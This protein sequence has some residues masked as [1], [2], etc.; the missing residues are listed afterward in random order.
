MKRKFVPSF[1]LAALLA[2]TGAVSLFGQ[3]AAP[4][5]EASVRIRKHVEYLTSD[6]L[7][8][9]RTGDPGAAAA[10]KYVADEFKKLKLQ[11]G[12]AV[13]GKKAGFMQPFPYV[14]GMTLANDSF[15]RIVPAD[16]QLES[17]TV[18]GETYM[19][20]ANSANG[21]VPDSTIVFA[22]YGIT[23]QDKSYDD[24]AG[25]DANGKVVI[26]FDG[27]PESGDP[28]SPLGLFN[29]HAKANVAKDH[30]ARA[31]ILI[32]RS[33]DFKADRASRL[34]FEP[35]MGETAV[36][37]VFLDRSV[38]ADALGVKGAAG[39]GQVEKWLGART[40]AAPVALG[41][42]K[43]RAGMK[44]DLVKRNV[45]GFNVIGVLPGSDPVLKDEAIVIGAHYDHLGRGGPGSLAAD[46]REI[47]HGADDNASGASALLELARQFAREKNNK[48][49]IIFMS[50]GGEEEGLL[51]S[52]FYV[53]NPTWPLG[54]TV[55]M[56]N[57]DM[58]G[59][60]NE[61]KL[62]V[63]G[64]GTAVGMKALVEKFNASGFKLQLNEDGL[65]PSDHASFY[66]KKV[67]VLFFFTGTHMD[68]HKPTD[69]AEKLNYAGIEQIAAMAGSIARHLDTADKR[70]SFTES[71]SS[72]METRTAFSV[73]LGTIPSY[74]DA[75]DGLVLDGV[76]DNG[77]AAKAGVKAGDKI[78]KLAGKDVR[79]ISDYMFAMS[80][81][82]A[83]QE[84]EI[85]VK[86]GTETLNLKVT[87]AAAGRR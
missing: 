16:P 74:A 86:R 37:V 4:A 56:V 55:A 47:H 11:P 66:L 39:A 72:G 12:V 3:A 34:S 59:R 7:E 36:P 63:G 5:S 6:R 32:A 75:T 70:L 79:N 26:A 17:K 80:T 18:P 20:Y 51:G 83:N 53:N 21:T 78:V 31:L 13:A 57:L 8:G 73:S 60:L 38:A 76:R 71:K 46:S 1:L 25:I 87:P 44:I 62:N 84:Y 28:H 61:G 43:A 45:D 40:G 52:K 54:N 35:S 77:P 85:V 9:R 81:M 22:G 64:I 65:G 30:G 14:A 15:I 23:T 69:T 48:R 58:V 41:P 68:Y 10:A 29:I 24:Y 33:D 2:S 49:T 67:P 50:F 27:I 42:L 19:P 82:K